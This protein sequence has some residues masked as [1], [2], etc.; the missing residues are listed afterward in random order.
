MGH[1]YASGQSDSMSRIC[2]TKDTSKMSIEKTRCMYLIGS[3]SNS[4][5]R[6]SSVKV[7][8]LMGGRC[9][10]LIH[11]RGGGQDAS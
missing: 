9:L 7:E 4:G 1:M 10:L 5:L 6:T 3:K 8:S 2:D 11:S